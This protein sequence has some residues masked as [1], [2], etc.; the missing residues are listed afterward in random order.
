V[1]VAL[2]REMVS[3]EDH[4]NPHASDKFQVDAK[5]GFVRSGIEEERETST[6]AGSENYILHTKSMAWAGPTQGQPWLISLAAWP[7][8]RESQSC[9]RP[10]QSRGFEAK[11]GRNSTNVQAFSP[12]DLTR[13]QPH[14]IGPGNLVGE[15]LGLRIKG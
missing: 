6:T 14:I 13:G 7:V 12:T 9:L 1:P 3:L 8:C 10:S 2:L 5:H 15:Y 11:P 4:F